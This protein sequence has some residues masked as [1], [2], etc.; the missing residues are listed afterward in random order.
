M[1]RV[2]RHF[3]HM[4]ISVGLLLSWG[5]LINT[6]AHRR[7]TIELTDRLAVIVDSK[8]SERNIRSLH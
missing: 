7:R 8:T 6:R 4:P 2:V 1:V 5:V 3:G